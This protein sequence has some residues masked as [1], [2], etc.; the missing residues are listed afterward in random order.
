MK[1]FHFVDAPP[2]LPRGRRQLMSLRRRFNGRCFYCRVPLTLPGEPR[3]SMKTR[4]TREHLI[5]RSM[6][7]RDISPNIVA[8]CYTCNC[9]RGTGSWLDYFVTIRLEQYNLIGPSLSLA[10]VTID[11]AN[12]RPAPSATSGPSSP[13]DKT[14][15]G[16]QRASPITF[17]APDTS[18]RPSY[19]PDL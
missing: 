2:R 9:R 6:G 13:K 5:P 12:E 7:G 8:A 16:S 10:P 11:L 1:Q 4:V 14:Q 3:S 19:P 17:T 15:T 18:Q